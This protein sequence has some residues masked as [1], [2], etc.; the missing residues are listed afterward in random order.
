MKKLAKTFL[1]QGHGKVGYI[2]ELTEIEVVALKKYFDGKKFKP[3]CSLDL[4]LDSFK[5]GLPR[6]KIK[7]EIMAELLNPKSGY[8][9]GFN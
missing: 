5:K 4:A 8:K 9:E 2:F 6:L 7:E 3:G 1:N